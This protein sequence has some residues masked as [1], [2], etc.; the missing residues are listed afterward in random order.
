MDLNYALAAIVRLPTFLDG[1]VLVELDVDFMHLRGVH[2]AQ[3][4]SPFPRGSGAQVQNTAVLTATPG[5]LYEFARG[6]SV[7]PYAGLGFA[8]LW[9]Q[10]EVI[11]YS[12]TVES[13]DFAFGPAL[14]GGTLAAL[15]PG[16]LVF[17]AVYREARMQLDAGQ[18]NASGFRFSA[19]YGFSL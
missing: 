3:T 8:I 10:T 6:G 2:S 9:T 17:E 18:E 11:A 5:V 1:A 13:R 7:V 15:G 16:T 19:G 14:I 4:S 12:Q